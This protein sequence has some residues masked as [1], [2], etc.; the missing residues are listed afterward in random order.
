MEEMRELSVAY[1]EYCCPQ[2]KPAI[3]REREYSPK[4]V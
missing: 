4:H 1:L 3:R 2:Y